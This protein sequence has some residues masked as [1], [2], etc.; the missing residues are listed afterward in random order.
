MKVL[1]FEVTVP[2]EYNNNNDVIAGWQSSLKN[3]VCKY[4]EDI[5]LCIAFETNS[6]SDK[7]KIIDGV[8]YIPI[9]LHYN[10]IEKYRNKWTWKI[11]MNKLIPKCVDVI[12][13]ITP[14]IIHVFGNEWPFGLVQKYTKIPVVIHIQGAIIPYNNSMYPPKYNGY[15]IWKENCLNIKKTLHQ[16]WN[17]LRYRDNVKMESEIWKCVKNYMGRTEWDRAVSN[18]EH[19]GNNYFHVEEALRPSFLNSDK[20]WTY[21]ETKKLKLI[22]TGCS[23][24]WKGPDML[25]KTAYCLKKMGIAFEWYVAGKMSEE[26]KEVIEKKEK[27]TFSDNNIKILGFIAP[28]SLCDILCDSSMYVHTAYIENSPNS[29]CEAQYLGIPIVSTHVGGIATLVKDKEEGIL[30]PA[31]DPWQMANAIAELSKDKMRLEMYST[32]SMMH[33]HERHNPKH[34]FDQLHSCYKKIIAQK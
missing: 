27:K 25:L 33:A 16:Y 29:I 6:S 12:N 28:D 10:I 15:T 20:H 4:C 30:V 31:N 18:V 11:K 22:T 34:I 2:S 17:Y 13:T 3:V 26:I 21:K 1:W 5:E 14:D 19:P 9:Y 8:T 32:N 24:Y 23:S 7:I